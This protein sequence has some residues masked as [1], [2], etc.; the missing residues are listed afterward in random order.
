MGTAT[1]RWFMSVPDRTES[2]GSLCGNQ[3]LNP[4]RKLGLGLLQADPE[5]R[6][7]LNRK[8][9]LLWYLP[10]CLLGCPAGSDGFK[11]VS[12][13]VYNNLSRGLATYLYWGYNPFTKYHGHS[14]TVFQKNTWSCFLC[15]IV[16]SK[17][18]GIHHHQTHH[19]GEYVSIFIQAS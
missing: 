3:K 5:R 7:I 16:Y 15:V 18:Y 8:T 4:K 9:H 2:N 10:G 19:F 6:C 17:C 1:A 11:N 13:L 14:S 12:K